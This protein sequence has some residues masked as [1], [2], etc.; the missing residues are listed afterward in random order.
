VETVAFFPTAFLIMLGVLQAIDPAL[1]ESSLNL[2]ATRWQVFRTVTLPL[3]VPGLASSL[4][5][6]FVESLADF[7]KPIILSGTFVLCP[8]VPHITGMVDF[9]GGA[10]L[11]VILLFPRSQRFSSRKTGW[12]GNPTAP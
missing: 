4:L 12:A 8:G 7:G 3:S 5:V 2:G 11:A 9:A 6:L 10:A 1:E